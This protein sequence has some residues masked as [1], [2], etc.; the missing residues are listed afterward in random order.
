MS[1]DV[2][3]IELADTASLTI[4]N[5]RGDD[6]LILADKPVVFQIYSPGSPQGVKAL[7]KA[8]TASQ[9]RTWRMMREQLDPQDAT[10]AEREYA[11]KLAGF[12]A[13]ISDNLPLTPLQ[14]YTNPRLCYIARQVDEFIAKL[15]NF[16]KGSSPS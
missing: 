6:D 14:V 12:T 11:E 8:G 10:N 15:G 4:K 7:H 13:S 2:S 5:A 16:S 1:F 9:K 3:Q